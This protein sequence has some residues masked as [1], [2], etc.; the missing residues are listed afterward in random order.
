M[1]RAAKSRD[2]SSRK[3]ALNTLSPPFWRSKLIKRN[4]PPRARR[5]AEDEATLLEV[6]IWAFVVVAVTIILFGIVASI[7]YSVTFVTQ[8]I[9]SMAPIDQAYTKMLNDIVLLIVGGI[10]GVI[11]KRAVSNAARAFSPQPPHQ[12]MCQPMMGGYNHSSYAPPQSAYG[13]PSQ[14]F[15]AMPIWNNPE[16][17]ESWTPGPPPTTPP[18]HQEPDEDRAE[19]AAARKESE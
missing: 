5:S 7:L 17:D 16:L 9:K 13:L 4:Q 8:P 2:A 1:P 14:P 10:G 6:R 11:G 3:L 19:I 18:E 12:P 15:G